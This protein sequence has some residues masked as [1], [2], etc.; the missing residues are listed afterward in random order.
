MSRLRAE[1]VLGRLPLHGEEAGRFAVCV[2]AAK[3]QK[4]ESAEEE[5]VGLEERR[6]ISESATDKAGK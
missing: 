5:R 3:R 2:D 6:H 4:P 1:H